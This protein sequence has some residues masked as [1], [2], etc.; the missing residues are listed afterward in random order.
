[1]SV[2]YKLVS[3]LC[4]LFG[5][6]LKSALT[7]LNSSVGCMNLDTDVWFKL[8]LILSMLGWVEFG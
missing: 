3:F 6:L 1:M 2:N 7:T 5:A 8:S 4:I